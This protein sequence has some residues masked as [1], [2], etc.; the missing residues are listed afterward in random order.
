[1][2]A[3]SQVSGVLL[4]ETDPLDGV[5]AFTGVRLRGLSASTYTVSFSATTAYRTLTALNNVSA[6]QE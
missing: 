5:A 1:M 4:G 2:C 6:L 3:V